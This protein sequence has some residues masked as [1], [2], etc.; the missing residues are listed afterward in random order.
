MTYEKGLDQATSV[1]TFAA[2]YTAP[3]RNPLSMA[4]DGLARCGAAWHPSACTLAVTGTR[5]DPGKATVTGALTCLDGTGGIPCN[6]PDTLV[7]Q[8]RDLLGTAVARGARS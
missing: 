4:R 7:P 8:E 1:M 2:D 6:A 3:P 5:Q